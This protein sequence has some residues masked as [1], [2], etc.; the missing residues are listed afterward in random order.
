MREN[1]EGRVGAD[2]RQDVSGV[3]A[4][5]AAAGYPGDLHSL[6]GQHS[7]RAD[8]RVVLQRRCHD[9]ARA[10]G[11]VTTGRD[12]TQEPLQGHV[13]GVCGVEGE[14]HPGFVADTEETRRRPSRAQQAT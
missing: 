4:A 9:V 11:P 1:H 6:G 13:E 2:G 10:N 7:Q 5:V 12:R 3:G 8:N 14:D